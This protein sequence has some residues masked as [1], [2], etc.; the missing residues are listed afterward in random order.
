MFQFAYWL[1][2]P[3]V[4]VL[5]LG[6]VVVSRGGTR[7][8]LLSLLA[9]Q[10]GVYVGAMLTGSF[11]SLSAMQTWRWVSLI[12]LVISPAIG[13]T[14][15]MVVLRARRQGQAILP[16]DVT[17]QSLGN[18]VPALLLGLLLLGVVLRVG[19]YVLAR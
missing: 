6:A 7:L 12:C 8:L 19:E 10:V 2:F 1:W 4:L 9:A 17:L 15:L 16:S 14:A 11:G 18:W 13:I 5:L 3:V